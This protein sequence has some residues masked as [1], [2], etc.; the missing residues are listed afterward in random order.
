MNE[1]IDTIIEHRDGDST[2]NVTY[3]FTE[4]SLDNYENKMSVNSSNYDSSL[5]QTQS[6]S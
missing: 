5:K 4:K 6:Q 2:I 1:Q 3:S